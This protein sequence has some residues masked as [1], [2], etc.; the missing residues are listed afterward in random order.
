MLAIKNILHP[1]DFSP[2]SDEAFRVAVSLAR[3]YGAKLMVLHVAEPP[4]PPTPEGVS[5]FS[6]VEH[7]EEMRRLLRDVQPHDPNVKVEREL[8]E[9]SPA[10]EIARKAQE[11]NSDVIVMGTHGRTGLGRLLMGSVAEHVLRAA[12]C[13]VM[14]IKPGAR[15]AAPAA[16]ATG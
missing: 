9:G 2:A 15:V 3:D 6:P 5:Y 10:R 1:T 11:L 4:E 16:L 14:T 12:P 13:M 8:V 7:L